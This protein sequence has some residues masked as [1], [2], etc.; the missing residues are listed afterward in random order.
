MSGVAC[1]V[2][3]CSNVIEIGLTGTAVEGS[4]LFQL[5][6]LSRGEVMDQLALVP[7]SRAGSVEAIW[8]TAIGNCDLAQKV[9][10]EGKQVRSCRDKI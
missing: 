6:A 7:G 1:A 9:M 8:V 5:H 4:V 3:L 10:T 2:F